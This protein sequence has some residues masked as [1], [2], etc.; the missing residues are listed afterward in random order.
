[1]PKQ[2]VSKATNSL[3]S[4]TSYSLTYFDSLNLLFKC[5]YTGY[6]IGEKVLEIVD[7]VARKLARLNNPHYDFRMEAIQKRHS[8]DPDSVKEFAASL[9]SRK[10]GDD[11]PEHFSDIDF[12]VC[13]TA[14]TICRF[15]CEHAEV[16]PLSVVSRITDTHDILILLV[17]LIGESLCLLVLQYSCVYCLLS[18]G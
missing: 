7:Y 16:L 2:E 13:T 3:T 18:S 15:I 4:Y 14:V 11:L 8:I 5:T 6:E 1:M 9:E 17:P 10:P 12:R